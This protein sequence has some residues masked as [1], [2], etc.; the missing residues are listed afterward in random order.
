MLYSVQQGME[1]VQ[2]GVFAFFLEE[3]YGSMYARDYF[4]DYEVCGLQEFGARYDFS[5]GYAAI[6][7]H[8]GYTEIF[9]VA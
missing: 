8:S 3:R 5:M 4:T 9:K 6:S 1:K 7:K 2:H